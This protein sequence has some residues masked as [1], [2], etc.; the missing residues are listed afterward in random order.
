MAALVGVA[1]LV[2]TAAI[3]EDR[4]VRTF[5]NATADWG[6]E[7]FVHL[8]VRAYRAVCDVEQRYG[9][10]RAIS[11]KTISDVQEAFLMAAARFRALLGLPSDETRYS[12]RVLYTAGLWRDTADGVRSLASF[13]HNLFRGYVCGNRACSRTYFSGGPLKACGGCRAVFFCSKKCQRA[14]W[15]DPDAAHRG[16]CA[17][18]TD[19][20]MR[21][22]WEG[23]GDPHRGGDFGTAWLKAGVGEQEAGQV[24]DYLAKIY[25]R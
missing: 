1:A 2:R 24:S 19:V 14:A 17:V 13:S 6:W 4:V 11:Q 3:Q 15:R 10:S 8:N 12:S 16:V 9:S 25:T 18:M 21:V 5:M 20:M 23:A 7:S 22:E